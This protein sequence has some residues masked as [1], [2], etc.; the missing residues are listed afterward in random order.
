[1]RYN[2]AQL[3]RGPTGQRRHYE[4]DEDLSALDEELRPVEPLTGALQF[5]RTSQGILVTGRCATAVELTC[6]RCLEPYVQAIDVEVEE[7]FYPTVDPGETPLDEVSEVDRED[8]ALRIDE[9][10]MLDLWE[11][12]RQNLLLAMPA[13]ALCQPDCQGL[14]PRCGESR[15]AGLCHC[16]T[17]PIDPRWAILQAWVVNPEEKE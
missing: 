11:V 8:V 2:V 4:L 10:H 13:H 3:I 16:P 9:H 7:E 1:M 15:N 14:C 17:E 6:D 12:M 5:T